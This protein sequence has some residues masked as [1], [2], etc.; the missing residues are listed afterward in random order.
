[1]YTTFII[2]IY[3]PLEGN[4]K[5]TGT[6]KY[7]VSKLHF[8]THLP[9][10]HRQQLRQATSRLHHSAH[11]LGRGPIDI[12]QIRTFS[13][14]EPQDCKAPRTN[15][16]CMMRLYTFTRMQVWLLYRIARQM[17]FAFMYIPISNNGFYQALFAIVI[18]NLKCV[19]AGCAHYH[20]GAR[21]H[22]LTTTATTK[23][24][25]NSIDGCKRGPQ[26]TLANG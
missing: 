19:Y 8:H 4:C 6:D 10:R 9:K 22:L 25:V 7:S 15:T 21:I 17:R 3:V 20:F 26:P 11:T 1:M 12:D 18:R 13:P 5:K 14:L 24:E 2:H 23:K 16:M